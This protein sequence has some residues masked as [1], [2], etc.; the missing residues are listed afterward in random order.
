MSRHSSPI[1][2]RPFQPRAKLEKQSSLVAQ[3]GEVAIPEVA[4]A[5]HHLKANGEATQDAPLPSTRK[6]LSNAA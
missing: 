3:Y 6:T 2:Q 1:D 4:E 5:L